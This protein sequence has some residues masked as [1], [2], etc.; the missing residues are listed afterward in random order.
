MCSMYEKF[1]SPSMF[2]R[3]ATII[4]SPPWVLDPKM[5]SMFAFDLK[6]G[7]IPGPQRATMTTERLLLISG[8]GR[9]F[10]LQINLECKRERKK[11]NTNK[12]IMQNGD[13]GYFKIPS[14]LSEA[15]SP[16]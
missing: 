3:T 13:L 10:F 1:T 7:F 4:Y 14:L 9:F 15:L 5:Y 8:T 2:V 12:K 11:K 6:W 16:F